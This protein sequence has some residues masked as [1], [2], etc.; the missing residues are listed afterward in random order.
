MNGVEKVCVGGNR[1]PVALK[2]RRFLSENLRFL[3][4]TVDG[5]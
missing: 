3:F 2:F 1:V 5:F 4:V